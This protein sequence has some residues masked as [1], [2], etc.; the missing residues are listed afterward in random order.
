MLGQLS[1]TCS[2][3]TV[4]ARELSVAVGHSQVRTI[5]S[6]TG[7]PIDWP[8]PPTLKRAV[9]PEL[10]VLHGANSGHKSQDLL[11][12]WDANA[13]PPECQAVTHPQ[14]APLT[15]GGTVLKESDDIYILGVTFNSKMIFEKHFRSV[16]KAAFQRLVIMRTL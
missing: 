7:D 2:N 13:Q 8:L 5:P 16:S 15:I 11:Q 6:E 3:A 10:H 12:L 1:I 4:V 14:S 9:P